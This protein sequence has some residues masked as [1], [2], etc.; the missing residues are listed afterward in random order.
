M[1]KLALLR[2]AMNC[3]TGLALV[4]AILVFTASTTTMAAIS[5]TADP[6]APGFPEIHVVDSSVF[7]NIIHTL[8]ED[9]QIRQTFQNPSQIDIGEIIMS[10]NLNGT[11]GTA[12]E[13][14]GEG[15][16]IIDIYTVE[17][18]NAA[19]WP[20][21]TP[22]ASPI[23]TW[24]IPQTTSIPETNGRLS[25]E[26]TGADIF[27]LAARDTGTQGYGIEISNVDGVTNM[28]GWHVT[29]A[30]EVDRYTQGVFFREDALGGTVS[31]DYRD[32]GLSI[33]AVGAS[34]PV[35]GDVTGDNLVGTDDFDIITQNFRTV[36]GS[37]TLGDLTGDG[38]VNFDDFREWKDNAPASV[39]AAV[40][41]ASVPE[42]TSLGLLMSSCGLAFL[43]RRRRTVV[44]EAAEIKTVSS[45]RRSVLMN[46]LAIAILLT[47]LNATAPAG[48]V[49]NGNDPDYPTSD[50]LNF[51]GIPDLGVM[52]VDPE[53]N[54]PAQRNVAGTRMLRQ[55]FQID[56]TLWPTGFN[57]GGVVLA[58]DVGTPQTA[59]LNVRFWNVEDVNANTFTP[60][61]N[62]I[63]TL[64]IPVGETIPE[65][66]A[67]GTNRLELTLSDFDLF[68]LDSQVIGVDTAGY[69]IELFTGDNV[70]NIAGW[71]HSNSGTDVYTEGKFYTETGAAS[72]GGSSG[73][74]AGFA[75][76][77]TTEEPPL[78]GDTDADGDVDLD[79]LTTIRQNFLQT[80]GPT[81][82]NFSGD[83]IISFE[84]FQ[85]WKDNKTVPFSG[86]LFGNVPEPSS[87]AI[88]CLGALMIAQR[89]QS[90]R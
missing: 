64:T 77:T 36:V 80:G 37:R 71:R 70:S 27:S 88:A 35:P 73:R 22:S 28:G 44:S 15:G 5:L 3:R 18:V 14:A 45:S 65:T 90:K 25:V 49:L 11:D 48:I 58:L 40:G 78:P 7:G 66:D 81:D 42:P 72:G 55:S 12:N 62:P 39:L 20:S 74:D 54:G 1:N 21:A 56:S 26:F 23:K 10:L 16:L 79:D 50:D 82:G 46:G 30:D 4:S 43:A 38:N 19:D 9:R 41:V 47:C 60:V 61:G 17:D 87:L 31:R 53:I 33:F 67:N 63:K 86:S 83:E 68:S 76:I 51:D 2:S 13:G 69:A 75:L 32:A 6:P 84:D 59:G 24:T 85:I 89:R 8:T 29:P 34:A 52:T 57:V